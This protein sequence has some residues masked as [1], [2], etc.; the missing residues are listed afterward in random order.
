MNTPKPRLLEHPLFS[1]R[2]LSVP[3]LVQMDSYSCGFVCALIVAR[4][5]G[6]PV[7]DL[8][9][10]TA[11]KTS[12][13]GTSPTNIVKGLR[14]LGVGANP[15]YDLTFDVVKRAIDSGK[16]V[17]LYNSKKDHWEVAYGYM[18]WEETLLV[19]DPGLWEE[20][21]RRP[22]S[23]TYASYG[24]VCSRHSK[25]KLIAPPTHDLVAPR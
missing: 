20:T 3:G 24:I 11:V 8:D 9:V 6:K 7:S 16:P 13:A 15:R 12:K 1:A 18:R 4:Y 21:D 19:A 14:R 10:Y 17:I 5:F 25:S 22:W 2:T 23:E